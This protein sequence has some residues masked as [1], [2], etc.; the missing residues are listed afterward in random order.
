ML[1][2]HLS[3]SNTSILFT[4]FHHPSKYS[5]KNHRKVIQAMESSANRSLVLISSGLCLKYNLKCGWI[6]H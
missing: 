4:K 2:F 1:R 6:E 5:K 3:R